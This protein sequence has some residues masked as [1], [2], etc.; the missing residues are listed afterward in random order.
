MGLRA[1]PLIQHLG[2]SLVA[3]KKIY[4]EE[5]PVRTTSEEKSR[6]DA[7]ARTSKVSRS[8]LLVI[9]TLSAGIPPSA[10]LLPRM[11]ALL[12]LRSVALMDLRRVRNR[13]SRIADALLQRPELFSAADLSE[14]IKELNATTQILKEQWDKPQPS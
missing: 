11:E 9:T 1:L 10:E 4:T 2:E 12:E 3:R 6:I 7:M 8:R 14:A 5:F 13:L